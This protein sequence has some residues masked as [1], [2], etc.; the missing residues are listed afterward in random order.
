MKK[1][2]SL[3]IITFMLLGMFPLK[4]VLANGF[5]TYLG[6]ETFST[7]KVKEISLA[8]DGSGTPYAACE[9]YLGHSITV[10]KYTGNGISGWE[11]VGNTSLPVG[12]GYNPALAIDN[13]GALYVAYEDYNK[14]NKAT[15]MKY[16][17]SV[18]N[19][20]EPVGKAGFSENKIYDT[21]LVIDSNGVLYA[22]FEDQAYGLKATVMK[23]NGVNW[24]NVGSAAFSAGRATCISLAIGNNDMP[25]LAY[26]DWGNGYKTTVMK[27]TGKGIYGW[28]SVG[29]VAFSSG[30]SDEISMKINSS[31]VP[32]VAYTDCDNGFQLTVMKYNGMNWEAVGGTGNSIGDGSYPSLNIDKSDNLYVAYQDSNLKTTL[33]KYNG[34][35]WEVIGSPSFSTGQAIT[36]SLAIDNK[37]IPYVAF[38][39]PNPDAHV[40]KYIDRLPIDAETPR[41]ITQP[42]D[43]SVD[44]GSTVTLSL[45]AAVTK[46]NLSYQWF[47]N[48]VN[49]NNGGILINGATESSFL[50]PT[51]KSEAYYYYC[52]VT[53]TDNT[54]TGN[55][56]T[57]IN[58]NPV[59]V[60]VGISKYIVTF[61]S[62]EGS[63]VQ[64]IA[65]DC[66]STITAPIKPTKEGYIF[67]GWYKER[68]CINAW[69]FDT[70]KV[71]SNTTLYAKWTD[72]CDINKDGTVSILDVA[73]VACDYNVRDTDAKW[74]LNFDFNKD[75][76]VDIFDLVTTSRRIGI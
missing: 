47:N 50:P 8:I 66:N 44:I 10:F 65:A 59:M 45:E 20:W 9:S 40:M 75:G 28:E 41:I 6:G 49:E 22:A 13:S 46:G 30:Q 33:K 42:T 3:I 21:S 43:I 37:G 69:G 52:K 14:D 36:I 29:N 70:D 53:N 60:N 18:S 34:I 56:T 68:S 71:T 15:V 73:L 4:T 48:T 38:T 5:F 25:Y 76:I 11:V 67:E 63:F 12:K 62:Q 19:S 58:S 1:V 61:N 23:F 24:E 51:T 39:D 54:A 74:N 72:I 32:Y 16:N 17:G 31:G 64:S 57:S 27:Y 2:I 7:E 55:K 26:R 35:S